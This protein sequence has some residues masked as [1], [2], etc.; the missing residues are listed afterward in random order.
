MRR[1][2]A[3]WARRLSSSVVRSS[4]A[5]ARSPGSTTTPSIVDVRG[6]ARITSPL[7]ASRRTY[8]SSGSARRKAPSSSAQDAPVEALAAAGAAGPSALEDGPPALFVVGRGEESS[9]GGADD[10]RP[11]TMSGRYMASVKGFMLAYRKVSMSVSG[12][13]SEGQGDT[14]RRSSI[15]RAGKDRRSRTTGADASSREPTTLSLRNRRRSATAER[16]VR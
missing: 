16:S 2:P 9:T 3:H 13:E 11:G 8:H 14:H 7:W 1:E 6:Q 15:S 10:L 12:G 5:L 4:S